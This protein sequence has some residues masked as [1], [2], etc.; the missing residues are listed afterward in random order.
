MRKTL[1]ATTALAA[2][3][4]FA[5]GTALADEMAEK[6]SVGV[7][8][9]M[10]QW[11]GGASVD[12]T[13]KDGKDLGDGGVRQYSDSEIFF[14]GSLEADNG[15]KFSV[16]VELEAN[17]S[18]GKEATPRG[19]QID[20]SQATVSGGFGEIQIG[21]ED[22]AASLMHYGNKDVGVGL[23]CGD[24]SFISG[25]SGCAGEGGLG[26]GTSGWLIGGDDQ[27]ISY[28]TPRMEGVQFGLS[29]IPDTDSEDSVTPALHN[30]HDA[31]AVGLNYMGGIGDTSVAL[32]AGYYQSDQVGEDISY[33]TGAAP[34]ANNMDTRLSQ[35]RHTTLEKSITDYQALVG[36]M[37]VA[38]AK[39]VATVDAGEAH[40][41][42]V[43]ATN[44]I[45]NASAMMAKADSTTFTNFGLQVGFG[46]FS[47]DVAYAVRDGGA[48][49]AMAM[50]VAMTAAEL[51]DEVDRIN[52]T[53]GRTAADATVSG[54]MIIDPANRGNF[55]GT[56]ATAT[57]PES[58]TNND[59]TNERWMVQRIV[60]DGAKDYEVASVGAMY[61]DGPM[62][63]SLS[64]M[65][66][67]DDAG[68]EASTA[69]LSGSYT[70]APG[71]DWKTSIFAGEQ[72]TAASGETDGTAFVT[73]IKL[74]F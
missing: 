8:G 62:A 16:K 55:G 61:S 63:I 41:A 34:A 36:L 11:I 47:F 54:T 19:D 42:A 12:A 10:E 49:K 53:A 45:H 40:A 37:P 24:A 28:F 66:A 17:S 70:L 1:L 73:G 20:E 18:E 3:G 58:A 33:V 69:M 43:D 48:Y 6:L 5:A 29:Y 7:S 46:A 52:A 30:D 74:N 15:L 26:L 67:E 50:P 31:V 56:G 32:S 22:H 27:K 72:S 60:K 71:I 2:A 4:A 35:K 39:T 14:K 13:D 68:G 21:S 59:P 38:P 23:N 65:M 57:T 44:R 64:Y 25:V 9:Y 51:D